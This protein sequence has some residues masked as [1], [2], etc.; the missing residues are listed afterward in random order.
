MPITKG[1][2]H[3][4]LAV[5]D[6]QAS[7]QFFV[8]Y[9]GWTESGFDP[10]YPRTAVSDGHIRLTLWQVDNKLQINEFNRRKNVGLHHLAL[11]IESESNL[12]ALHSTLSAKPDVKIEF[13]P[14]DIGKGPR[15]HFIVF[16]PSGLRI[17]FTWPGVVR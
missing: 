16:D 8:E 1:L 4:G 10:T 17:E 13:A 2:N 3:L 7:T 9:L 6:L 5:L 15:K 12:Y 14:E 11:E